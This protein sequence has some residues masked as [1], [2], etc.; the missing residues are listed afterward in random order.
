MFSFAAP[1]RLPQTTAD[2]AATITTSDLQQSKY[3]D[4]KCWQCGLNGCVAITCG[5]KTDLA[6]LYV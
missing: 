4:P 3:N 6:R 2:I 5:I 1:P